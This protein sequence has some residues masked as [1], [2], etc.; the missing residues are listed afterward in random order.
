[1]SALGLCVR[2]GLTL[3]IVAAAFGGAPSALKAKPPPRSASLATPQSLVVP[4]PWRDVR[5]TGPPG[6]WLQF[7]LPGTG[8]YGPYRD[9]IVAGS[10]G[11]IWISDEQN[12]ELLRTAMDGTTS[13]FP[14]PVDPSGRYFYPG[15]IVVGPGARLYVG[16][17]LYGGR[18]SFVGAVAS[19][20][21]S[22][23]VSYYPSPSG[24]LY[25]GDS[26]RGGILANSG[27]IW[28]TE[29]AHVAELTTG[30]LVTEY[31]Y[32]TGLTT[33]ISGITRGADGHLWF[34]EF[35]GAKGISKVA[36]VDP[37]TGKIIDFDMPA[38][39]TFLAGPV[40]GSDGNVY[41]GCRTT[42][43]FG[44][45]VGASPSGAQQVIQT[46][47][48]SLFP[49]TSGPNGTI[50]GTSVSFH[51]ATNVFTFDPIVG[52]FTTLLSP[53]KYRPGFAVTLGPDGN[54]WVADMQ[55]AVDVRLLNALSVSPA[56]VALLPG[57]SGTL[58]A[59]YSGASRLKAASGDPSIVRVLR[60][61]V[62]EWTVSA[63]S[64]GRTTVTVQDEIQNSFVVPITVR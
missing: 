47:D 41:I 33:N 59:T 60:S 8:S 25:G 49:E 19:M 2:R 37:T 27:E 51:G 62:K 52:A 29:Q 18:S 36:N 13:A 54:I 57:A 6:K 9:G 34:V 5:Q 28:F 23:G 3:S 38:C 14:F 53:K 4:R 48:A 58:R 45:L 22:G 56:H 35:D 24:D 40:A 39:H 12:N 31:A 20:T 50:L 17:T 10:D 42:Y 1:M 43:G 44:I 21:A 55:R 15:V 64:R 26:S 16:G 11:N 63:F 30:G 32:P 7:T 46:G 61:G